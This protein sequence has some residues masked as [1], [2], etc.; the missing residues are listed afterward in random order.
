M[1]RIVLK[2]GKVITPFVVEDPGVV[3]FSD[4]K[5]EYVGKE[6]QPQA[7]DEVVDVTGRIVA[8]GLI[9][10]HIHGG[11][12]HDVMGGTVEDVLAVAKNELK[13]GVT[14]FVPSLYATAWERMLTALDRI[15]ET[16]ELQ[17]QRGYQESQIVGIY[18]E[19]PFM[20]PLARGGQPLE[21]MRKPLAED[22]LEIMDRAGELL[23]LV[24]VAPELEGGMD[25][26]REVLSRG[27]IAAIGH[28]E[29]SY[30][31]VV[32]AVS[33]GLDHA[34]HVFNGGNTGITKR[35][36]G[37]I[38]AA[39]NIDEI[40]C[41][42]ICDGIHVHQANMQLLYKLKSSDKIIL[43]TDA[44]QPAGL[45][46]GEYDLSDGRRVRVKNNV[47]TTADAMEGNLYGSCLGLNA[48]V[49]NMV[50]MV[51]ATLPE[52]I[53]MAT[54]N[55][56]RRLGLTNKGSLLPGKDADIVVFSSEL[57]V[58]RVFIGGKEMDLS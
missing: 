51:G 56:A 27:V 7:G 43:I 45:P 40:Y 23:R 53:K 37:L 20:N 4:G 32:E 41:E 58:E 16:Y 9:D 57:D 30:E 47:A 46:D 50:E 19:A 52:A 34:V 18:L 44:V 11:A 36:P 14:A 17:Q 13:S 3:V 55:P 22:Y 33:I 31:E 5:I 24:L 10:L 6:Y 54:V 15:N 26:T 39:L 8:P 28:S 1:Q 2:G 38:G 48:G 21:H 49:K 29:A 25:L 42:L 35:Q 12:G